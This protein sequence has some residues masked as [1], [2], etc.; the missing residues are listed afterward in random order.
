MWNFISSFH[1][2]FYSCDIF[3]ISA[4]LFISVSAQLSCLVHSIPEH[5]PA[6]QYDP[7]PRHTHTDAVSNQTH[8]NCNRFYF[9]IANIYLT[10][11][12]PG[13]CCLANPMI[14]SGGLLILVSTFLLYAWQEEARLSLLSSS[15]ELRITF[16]SYGAHAD[17]S[18]PGASWSEQNEN[19]YHV[20][21][22][23]STDH[24]GLL[25][26]FFFLICR[27]QIKIKTSFVN[28][29]MRR[30]QKIQREKKRTW[31]TRAG[32]VY[33]FL[34]KQSVIVHQE[35]IEQTFQGAVDLASKPSHHANLISAISQWLIFLLYLVLTQRGVPYLCWW[36]QI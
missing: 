22:I 11:E 29:H 5:V 16:H 2:I 31:R 24:T 30:S 27:I 8:S 14:R 17:H 12:A 6:C 33:P 35:I 23:A 34:W 10:A 19:L 28:R 3:L 25:S 9:L 20:H 15:N 26:V 4:E 21:D 32:W 7:I 13:G 18:W 36:R 1:F